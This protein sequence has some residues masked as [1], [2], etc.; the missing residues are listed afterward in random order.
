MIKISPERYTH[1]FTTIIRG[2]GGKEQF[3]IVF[4]ELQTVV[5]TTSMLGAAEVTML[6]PK[7]TA[8]SRANALRAWAHGR[9]PVTPAEAA[10]IEEQIKLIVSE[11]WALGDEPP[12]PTLPDPTA[13]LTSQIR[14]VFEGMAPGMLSQQQQALLDAVDKLETGTRLD[15]GRLDFLERASRKSPTGVTFDYVG[16]TEDGPSGWR[17]MRHHFIGEQK[18]TLR[19][20]IDTVRALGLDDNGEPK[21]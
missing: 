9:M 7:A 16:A 20:A 6:D 18:K 17:F 12:T 13:L 1:D 14:A 5:I 8:N 11:H 21:K 2:N 10:E 3:V 19:Q 4:G 15:K